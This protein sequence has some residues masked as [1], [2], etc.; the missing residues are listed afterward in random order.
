LDAS[1]LVLPH[2]GTEDRLKPVLFLGCYDDVVWR[3]SCN[4][5]FQRLVSLGIY[6]L[7][8]FLRGHK[9]WQWWKACLNR[10]LI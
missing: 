2:F 6:A 10:W 1:E 8:H 4:F 7:K 9:L 3:E 5:N